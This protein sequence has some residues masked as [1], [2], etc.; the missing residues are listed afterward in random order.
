MATDHDPKLRL[1]VICANCHSELTTTVGKLHN[2][3][4]HDLEVMVS[5]CLSC[6]PE[7]TLPTKPFE[8]ILN[9]CERVEVSLR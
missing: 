4:H 8:V 9:D 6:E 3:A 5:I 1:L 2:G 7:E